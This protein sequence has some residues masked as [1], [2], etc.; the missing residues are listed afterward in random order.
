MMAIIQ[1]K[2]G[3]ASGHGEPIDGAIAVETAKQMN[4]KYG[5]GTHWVVW[6]DETSTDNEA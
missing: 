2:I 4:K 5:P 6:L 1:W 3:E